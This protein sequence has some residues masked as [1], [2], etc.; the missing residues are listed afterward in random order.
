MIYPVFSLSGKVLAFGGRTLRKDKD[1]AKYVNSPESLIYHKSNV[2][3]GLYQARKSIVA[4]DKCI[5]VEGYMDV[6]SMHQRG[7]ENVVASSGTSLTDGQIRL[8]HRFTPNVTVIY[9]SDAAGIKASLR[10]IDMLLAE[11][12]NVKVLLLPDGDDPDSFAQSHS[13]SEVEEYIAANETDFIRFKTTI[14]LDGVGDNDPIGRSRVIADIVRSISVIPEDITRNE[15]IK[16]CSRLLNTDEKVLSLQVA[17]YGK[18]RIEKEAEK[19]QRAREREA[20]QQSPD[21][22]DAADSAA[23]VARYAQRASLGDTVRFM[24]PY[25]REVLRYALKYGMLYLC[26]ACD[27]DGNTRPVSVLE[28]IESEL[29]ADDMAFSNPIWRR[30]S[31]PPTIWPAGAG[32]RMRPGSASSLSS[33]VGSRW[34]RASNAY[35]S[36]LL[37]PT[38]LPPWRSSCVSVSTRSSMQA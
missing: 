37:R 24:R 13:A 15:Y 5:L 26:D 22:P 4:H 3:Y 23:G 18:E 20:L 10:G 8:I 12:L 35:A 1:V 9:D 30:R 32:R 34:P 27:D 6:I 2:L 28:Y 17:R 7:V 25:E 19:A 14:L 16:E 21:Q 31:G 38:E 36:R 33:G 29:D 11:G